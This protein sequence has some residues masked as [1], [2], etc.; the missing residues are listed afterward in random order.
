MVLPESQ[1]TLIRSS[2]K[3]VEPAVDVTGIAMFGKL[4]N[5]HPEAMT[6]FRFTNTESL[7]DQLK[8]NKRLQRHASG[9]IKTVGAAIGL[10]DD[11]ET[12]VSTLTAL[13]K[14]HIK[15][16]LDVALFTPVG[17]ALLY[18][19]QERIGTD[20]SSEVAEAWVALYG[21][22]VSVMSPVIEKGDA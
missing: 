8:N 17:E 19:L 10:L 14:R 13:A 16:K 20:W 22:V 3:H 12:L 2:W 18:A 6:L 1:K 21:A 5:D 11:T 15:Y 4:F 9:V 7:E